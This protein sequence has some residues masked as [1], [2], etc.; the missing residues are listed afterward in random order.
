MNDQ[1][2]QSVAPTL[3]APRSHFNMS[4]RHATTIDFDN[5]YP[6]FHEEVLPG[7]TFTMQASVFGRFATLLNPIMDN[8]Y[9]DLHFFYAPTRILWNN[10]RKFYG[11]QHDPGDSIDYTVPIMTAP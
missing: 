3:T 7:D 1:Y 10:A 2:I 11:E 4:S 9:L 6:V 5:I 8:T